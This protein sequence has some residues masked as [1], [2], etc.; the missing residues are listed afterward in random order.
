MFGMVSVGDVTPNALEG[1]AWYWRFHW[2][3]GVGNPVAVQLMV[4]SDPSSTIGLAE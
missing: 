2:N 3:T 1:I 4:R